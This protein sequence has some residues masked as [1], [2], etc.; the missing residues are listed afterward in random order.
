MYGLAVAATMLATDVMFYLVVRRALGWSRA[1]AL[2]IALLFGVLDAT[3]VAAGLPKFVDGAWVPVLVAAAISIV[4]ITWLTGRRSVARELHAHVEPL[5]TFSKV[6]R[7]PSGAPQGAVVLLS[8]DPTGV[9]FVRSHPWLDRLIDEAVVVVLNVTFV[10]RPYV[11]ESQRV[12]VTHLAAGL[13][14]VSAAFGYME[15]PRIIP[16]LRACDAS[17]LAI[18]KDTTSFVYSQPVI[19]GKACGGMPRLQ[20][21][22]FDVVQRLARKL[23][24]DLEIKASRQI[25]IAIEVAV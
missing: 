22:L 8:G 2:P 5:E 11:P 21:Q 15:P 20:R 13:V 6:R 12:T 25:E 14:R 10:P 17:K 24:T 18:D 16:I 7:E 9:P 3:F 1:V 4:A 19:V 23:A